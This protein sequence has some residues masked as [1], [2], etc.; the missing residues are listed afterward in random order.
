MQPRW[1]S[2][3][4]WAGSA[5]FFPKTCEVFHRR[6]VYEVRTVTSER[7][8]R[9]EWL[10][11]DRVEERLRAARAEA[12]DELVSRI[13]KAPHLGARPSTRR[14]PALALA[15]AAGLFATLAGLGGVGYAKD[16]VS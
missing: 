10:R 1:P 6:P 5:R 8:G 2:A 13:S 3:G 16:A 4:L 14:R 9:M 11:N 12:P 15:L 7:I